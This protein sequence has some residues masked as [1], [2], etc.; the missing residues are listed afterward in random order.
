MTINISNISLIPFRVS[1]NVYTAYT[2]DLKMITSN[3]TSTV[4][5]ITTQDKTPNYMVFTTDL[6]TLNEGQYKY[7]LKGDNNTLDEGIFYL[8][9]VDGSKNYISTTTKQNEY[10]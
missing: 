6:S 10:I 3:Y 7:I 9:S 2:L 5:L 4:T 8:K 1:E